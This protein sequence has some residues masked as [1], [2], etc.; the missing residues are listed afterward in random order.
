MCCHRPFEPLSNYFRTITELLR[1]GILLPKAPPPERVDE[2]SRVPFSLLLL[3]TFSTFGVH[4]ADYGTHTDPA[5]AVYKIRVIGGGHVTDGSAVLVAPGR[6]LTACHVTRRAESIQAGREDLRWPAHPVASDIEHDLCVLAIP[7][8]PAA[9]SAVI[10]SA[11]HLQIG[12]PV[13][14]A[15]Y[16]RGG[17]L[18]VSRGEIKGL[19]AHDGARVLQVSTSFNHGQSGGGLFDA[20]GR[21]IG[22][23]GFKAVAGGNFQYALPLAWAGD[24]IPGQT[25]ATDDR[26]IHRKAFWERSAAEMPLFLRAASLEANR[27]WKALHGVAQ[28]WVMA[29]ANNPAS[30]LCLGRILT[31]LK[32]DQAA[33]LAFGQAAALLPSLAGKSDLPTA[34]GGV[35]EVAFRAISVG[36]SSK[37]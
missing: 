17:K 37:Q 25:S 15:G 14:A 1:S 21:L 6:L 2:M 28:E 23:I 36:H 9:T 7:E 22:I 27:N 20:A 4:A 35:A 13:I 12:D 10:G 34:P 24:A 32:R 5:A 11:E 29:D 8:L 3:L 31:R 18:D 16:P 33:A 26:R 19:H 30:W